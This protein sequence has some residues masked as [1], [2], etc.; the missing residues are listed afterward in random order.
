MGRLVGLDSISWQVDK[1]ESQ[2]GV[3]PKV[4]GPAKSTPG[5]HE[6]G[7]LMSLSIWSHLPDVAASEARLGCPSFPVGAALPPGSLSCALTESVYLL[8]EAAT[9][10][11][12]LLASP[13][14]CTDISTLSQTKCAHQ[15]GFSRQ[16]LCH[17]KDDRLNAVPGGQTNL[18][19]GS[20]S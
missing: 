11:A 20:E 4:T 15:T 2:F 19:A 12:Y 3:A 8:D 13:Q 10:S 18:E 1:P 17:F 14:K 16:I 7:L 6:H 5:F 9:A